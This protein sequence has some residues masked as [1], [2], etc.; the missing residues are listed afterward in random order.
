MKQKRKPFKRE[1]EWRILTRDG[2]SRVNDEAQHALDAH[3]ER[4]TTADHL[5]AALRAWGKDPDALVFG[6]SEEIIAELHA[7]GKA[8]SNKTA[9]RR[10][11]HLKRKKTGG[12]QPT[13]LSSL[14]DHYDS[15]ES[16]L[17]QA[18]EW[19]KGRFPDWKQHST[20][21]HDLVRQAYP[22]LAKVDDD[23]IER[24]SPSPNLGNKISVL[25]DQ[26][27]HDS[28]A[29]SHIALE[30]AARSCGCE[31]YQTGTRHLFQTLR[32]QRSQ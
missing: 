32:K 28:P 13:D 18:K 4:L 21:W 5:R 2:W 10:Q 25:M 12:R 7:L 6:A 20:P 29:T 30:H 9:L 16:E 22:A 8:L 14:L 23:L 27:D 19:I 26:K 17:S 1:T 24:L 11:A 3:S 31:P 15:C